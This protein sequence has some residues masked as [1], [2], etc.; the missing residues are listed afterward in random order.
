MIRMNVMATQRVQIQ[1]EVTTVP[2]MRASVATDL[3]VKVK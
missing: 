3:N 2:V 1:E